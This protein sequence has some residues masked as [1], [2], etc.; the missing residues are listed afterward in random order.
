VDWNAIR[1][2]YLAGGTSYRKLAEKYKI[3]LKTIEHRGKT[4]GW[5]K[6]KGQLEGKIRAKNEKDVVKKGSKKSV[7][8]NTVADKLLDRLLKIAEGDGFQKFTPKDIKEMTVALRNIK[9]IKGE[10]SALDMQEQ[11]ARIKNLEKQA[12]QDNETD[13]VEVVMNEFEEYSV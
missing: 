3:P 1:A 6:Q 2:E 12:L 9:D 4:E 13:S 8:I 10:K 11:K 7:K 5:V